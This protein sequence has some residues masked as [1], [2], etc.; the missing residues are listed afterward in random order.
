MKIKRIKSNPRMSDR[1]KKLIIQKTKEHYRRVRRLH[2]I[3]LGISTHKDRL[4]EFK[5]S[6]KDI[7]ER[8]KHDRKKS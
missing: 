5:E 1:V 8:S 2:R 6:H 4:E 7:F 3:R